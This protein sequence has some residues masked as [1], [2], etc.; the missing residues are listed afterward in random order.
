MKVKIKI[1][2]DSF[3]P[4]QL[5]FL[6]LE[7]RFKAYIGGIGSGK[8]Y[9]GTVQSLIESARYP[10]TTGLIVAPTYPMIRDVVLTTVFNV[11]PREIIRKY[12]ETKHELTLL[13]GSKILFRSADKPD[14]LRGLNL[15]S[16]M[17]IR[18][19]EQ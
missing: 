11:F 13:N 7:N 5:E 3:I 18:P 4:R 19:L 12:L 9:A 15:S 17:G 10:K 16:A 14:K 6:K 1:A 8:T 2:P